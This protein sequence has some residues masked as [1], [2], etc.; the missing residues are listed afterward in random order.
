MHV[1][2]GREGLPRA[3]LCR[4]EQIS[5]AALTCQRASF[6]R[7]IAPSSAGQP[8]RCRS[9]VLTVRALKNYSNTINE[10]G[11]VV[12]S[13]P[14]ADRPLVCKGLQLRTWSMQAAF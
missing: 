14:P 3:G 5:A 11:I 6:R 12:S 2:C 9:G 13:P 7:S 4:V 8:R 10:K 1:R